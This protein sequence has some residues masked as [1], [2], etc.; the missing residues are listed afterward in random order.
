MPKTLLMKLVK[1][2]PRTAEELLSALGMF[3]S[4]Q[5]LLSAS[6]CLIRGGIAVTQRACM[7]FCLCEACL[8]AR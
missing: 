1:G 2:I 6:R 7:A 4:L 3:V 8:Y 5:H